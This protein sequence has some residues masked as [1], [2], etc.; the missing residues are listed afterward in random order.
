MSL[1]CFFSAIEFLLFPLKPRNQKKCLPC[2]FQ[3]KPCWK[4]PLSNNSEH[5]WM[6]S[7]SLQFCFF[8]IVFAVNCKVD[9]IKYPLDCKLLEDLG[10]HL[11]KRSYC[12]HT[13]VLP[14]WTTL[15]MFWCPK[16][17]SRIECVPKRNCCDNSVISRKFQY[18]F[19]T[20]YVLT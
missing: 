8:A 14:R 9:E 17:V 6:V 2:T 11:N 16:T 1:F 10:I 5:T 7:F 3:G 15:W 19:S 13:E 12:H 4:K 18:Q 20:I